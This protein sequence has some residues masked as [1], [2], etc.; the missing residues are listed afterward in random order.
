MWQKVDNQ[1]QWQSNNFLQSWEWGEFQKSLG[2]EVRRLSWDNKI[3]VQAI[4]M[5]LP[6]GKNYWY[7]PHA[8]VI[9]SQT[10]EAFAAMSE[11]VDELGKHGVLFLRVD[12]IARIEP[13]TEEQKQERSNRLLE[14]V[15]STQP[16]CTR[17]LDL[18]RTEELLLSQ[19][20]QKTRYNIRLAQKKGVEVREGPIEDFFKLNKQTKQRDNFV[21]HPD[22]H[23]KKMFDSLPGG[24]I[25]I[26][27]AECDG[28]VLSSNIILYFG[29]TATYAHGASSNE[30]RE[31]MGSHLLQWNV[32]QDAKSK[33][34]KYYDFYGVN[35]EDEEHAAYKESWK[36]ISR[37]K[38][39]FG[40][41][42]ICYPHSFDLI[43]K[44]GWYTLYKLLRKF[45]RL[46]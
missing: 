45:R 32:I 19:M 13:S 26:W 12:P 1:D 9:I 11:L 15:P 29:D 38:Q 8:P 42:L 2:R 3:F 34:L 20:H 4:K 5:N 33:G 25:K 21:S 39:G 37:F 18:S 36:G 41:E 22:S 28:K 35:P 30:N 44:N 24:F 7:I 27:N 31:L 43:Y 14:F 23:Y 6:L 17:V 10:P 16:R 40:G 46:V